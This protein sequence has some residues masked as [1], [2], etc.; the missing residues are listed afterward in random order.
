MFDGG[1]NLSSPLLYNTENINN[2]IAADTKITNME[3]NDFQAKFLISIIS[4]IPK[5]AKT[6][7]RTTEIANNIETPFLNIFLSL[8]FIQI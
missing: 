7:N 3:L 1:G 8:R 4:H 6:V 2:K 5:I